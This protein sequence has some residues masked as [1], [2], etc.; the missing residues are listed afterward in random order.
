MS[1]Q[2]PHECPKDG[3]H[4]GHDCHCEGK[5]DGPH[6]GPGH[7]CHKGEHKDCGCHGGPK[8]GPHGGPNEGPH[9]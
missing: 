5:K 9:H 8:D 3:P 1:H 4:G 6:G 2:G 7:E